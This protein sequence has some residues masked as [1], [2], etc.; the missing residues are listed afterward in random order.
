MQFYCLILSTLIMSGTFLVAEE[1]SDESKTIAKIELL[2]G[3]V[4][5]NETLPD[6][7]VIDL[8]GSLTRGL[9]NSPKLCRI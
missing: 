5:R 1:G 9:M 7:P 8:P 2:G 6:R 3:K 4:T